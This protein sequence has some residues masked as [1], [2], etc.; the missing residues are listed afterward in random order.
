VQL[1]I[2][3]E[4]NGETFSHIYLRVWCNNKWIAADASMKL[5][6]GD[7]YKGQKKYFILTGE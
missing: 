7:E 5:E 2:Y 3:S 1:V 6:L 4:D